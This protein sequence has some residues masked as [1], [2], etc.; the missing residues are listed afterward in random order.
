MLFSTLL[1]CCCC[2]FLLSKNFFFLHFF[3][4]ALGLSCGVCAL[5]CR[6]QTPECAG[7]KAVVMEL[8][9]SMTY[10]ILVP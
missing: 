6:V 4:A 7:S 2:V 8:S 5:H 9:C 3:M 10:G 1:F